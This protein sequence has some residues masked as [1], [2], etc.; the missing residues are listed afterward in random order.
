MLQESHT[1]KQPVV[2]QTFLMLRAAS[3]ETEAETDI[4]RL[5]RYL[6]SFHYST[7]IFIQ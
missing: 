6:L 2:P 7:T 3:H 1:V 5:A 4:M